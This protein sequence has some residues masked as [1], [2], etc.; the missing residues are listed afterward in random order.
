MAALPEIPPTA[1][2][3]CG[4]GRVLRAPGFTELLDL[5]DLHVQVVHPELMR[6]LSPLELARPPKRLRRRPSSP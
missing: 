3:R 1:S 6:T 4:C 5:A 2:V